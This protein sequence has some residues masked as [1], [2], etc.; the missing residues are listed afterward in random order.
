[1][2]EM[3]L[4]GLK[5]LDFGWV[6][7][8]PIM[9]LQLAQ[10][11]AHVVRV[12]SSSRPDASR[13]TAPFVDQARTVSAAFTQINANKQSIGLNLKHSEARSIILEL[14]KWADVLTENFRPGTLEKLGLGYEVLSQANPKLV[15][16]RSSSAGQVG[17]YSTMAATGDLLQS[18]CGFTH[19]TGHAD[20]KP[21]PPWGAWTD[22]TVPPMG[23]VSILAAVR[24]AGKTGQGVHIDMSQHE[25][26]V[27]FLA[28]QILAYEATGEIPARMGNDDLNASPHGLFPSSDD[29]W[30][31]IEVAHR[32]QWAALTAVIG[33]P[34]WADHYPSVDS[35]RQAAYII[36][37]GISDWTR[38]R[39][40][41]AAMEELQR[42]G[43]P[44]GIVADPADVR[45]DPQLD[46]REY[47]QF[48]QEASVGQVL[49]P[50]AAYRLS[51][52]P[53]SIKTAAPALGEHTWEVCS[54]IL[55]LDGDRIADLMVSGALE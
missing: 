19:L 16:L 36:S 30:V 32:E 2:S 31:A 41:A 9:T 27:G 24:Q 29:G 35:R 17:E 21:M 40:K 1:M 4:N 15:V 28:D 12:E 34:G 20:G 33:Q 7:A 25:L 55:G 8:V 13:A 52:T 23:V 3:A 42:S 14:V 22:I 37:A 26:S 47:F 43:V 18:L 48:T 44:A 6:A 53:A 38:R 5:V 46:Y 39:T 11:G 45:K 49:S 10:H 51:E 50:A 54:E